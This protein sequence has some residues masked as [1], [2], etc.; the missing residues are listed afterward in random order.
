MQVFMFH[1]SF[2]NG[3]ADC[4]DLVTARCKEEAEDLADI[5]VKTVKTDRFAADMNAKSTVFGPLTSDPVEM[6]KVIYESIS[7]G[8]DL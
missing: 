6:M 1:G 7:E 3:R 5:L 8:E 4:Y 2:T